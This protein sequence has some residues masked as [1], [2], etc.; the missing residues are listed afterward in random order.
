MNAERITLRSLV[1]RRVCF[2]GFRRRTWRYHG[3]CPWG[4]IEK[5][6]EIVG[7]GQINSG[8]RDNH[9]RGIVAEFLK[10]HIKE[11]SHLSIV[12]AFFTIYAYEAL[13]D[14]LNRIGHMDFLF[15]EPRFVRS[16]DPDKTEK[17]SFII[18]SAGLKSAN[19]LQQKRIAKEC[20]DW[21]RNKV[22]IKSV[23]QTNFL[24]GKMYHTSTN[25]VEEAILGN[26]NF[27]A[28][29][30]G[31]S[32]S[33]SNRTGVFYYHGKFPG[34]SEPVK[35]SLEY[36]DNL[37]EA[38]AT[39]KDKVISSCECISQ[40]DPRIKEAMNFMASVFRSEVDG[41]EV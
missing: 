40:V 6:E 11:G 18:D 21:I 2:G 39:L 24:H 25:G 13:K 38:V 20:A 27:T 33:N 34:R 23:K 16:L 3:L 12:S 30:P 26:S 19:C 36:W 17:K 5:W 10:S 28:H 37:E 22:L 32:A 9:T 8:I 31:L 41:E 4:S 29:G 15:G 35:E 1:R 7:E 14:H